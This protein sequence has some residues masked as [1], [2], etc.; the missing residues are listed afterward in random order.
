MTST[1]FT[2]FGRLSFKINSFWVKLETPKEFLA[3]KDKL[4]DG[5]PRNYNEIW[6]YVLELEAVSF[7]NNSNNPI[8]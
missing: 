2:A 1:W 8:E 4:N 5:N 3:L 7:F 6:Y